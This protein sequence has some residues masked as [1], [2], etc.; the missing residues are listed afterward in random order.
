MN[1]RDPAGLALQPRDTLVI[2][3]HAKDIVFAGQHTNVLEDEVKLLPVL[4]MERVQEDGLLYTAL[5]HVPREGG[6]SR[7]PAVVQRLDLGVPCKRR[8]M[9]SAP[10]GQ[11]AMRGS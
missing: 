5:H 1:Q 2:K 6:G 7:Q 11:I 9:I 3:S 8:N 4:Q 10:A